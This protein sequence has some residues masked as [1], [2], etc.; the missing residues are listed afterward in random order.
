MSGIWKKHE[1]RILVVPNRSGFFYD[2]GHPEGIYYKAFDEFQRFVNQKFKTGCRKTN[3][4]FIP[5]RPDQL[6]EGLLKEV[7]F[8][9]PIDS[10]VKLVIVTG[11]KVPPIAS[12]ED[13]SGKKVYVNPAI[14][15]TRTCST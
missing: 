8:T 9:A 15:V 10:N 6:E 13:L 1:I 12:A 4:A 2:R 14:V 3:I 5:A 7:L 11:P